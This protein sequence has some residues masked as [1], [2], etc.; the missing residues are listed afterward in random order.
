MIENIYIYVIIWLMI[1]FLIYMIFTHWNMRYSWPVWLSPER[2]DNRI[3]IVVSILVILLLLLFLFYNIQ[4]TRQSK[5]QSNNTGTIYTNEWC[6]NW[7]HEEN[8]ICISNTKICNEDVLNWTW[9]EYYWLSWW[10]TCTVY[11]DTWY[12][13]MINECVDLDSLSSIIK[14]I[15][16]NQKEATKYKV[17]KVIDWDTI[18]VIT[19]KNVLVKVRLLWINTPE[20]DH[21]NSLNSDC[22]AFPAKDYLSNMILG[23]YIYLELDDSQSMYDKY[24]RLL[25]YIYLDKKNINQ[26]M[27]NWWYAR[28]YTYDKLYK[29][30]NEFLKSQEIAKSANIWLW[31]D[32]KVP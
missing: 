1:W 28:E 32:C 24:G 11:C 5:N 30:T 20:I 26:D 14:N 16:S 21:Q 31:K 17:K 4:Y 9:N 12:V 7:F 3:W 29:Y 15:W 19:E 18:I 23:K 8:N 22:F 2:Q 27:L 6:D 25:A 13:F 10:S